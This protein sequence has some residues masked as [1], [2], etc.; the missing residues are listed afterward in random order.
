MR[1]IGN[2]QTEDPTR[3]SEQL[4]RFQSNVAAE[5][6]NIRKSFT[7]ALQ[8]VQFLGRTT[9]QPIL[10]LTTGQ[11]ALCDVSVAALIIPLM[12]PSDGAPGFAAL[13]KKNA[14]ATAITL[15]P[16]GQSIPGVART[17][18]GAAN[19]AYTTAAAGLFWL[20]FDGANW[21]AN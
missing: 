2:F 14:V 7:P 15:I 10:S 1:Q 3:L 18:N 4:D 9:N 8:P 11:I 5:T 16:A 19:K 12:A 20:F 21:W 13:V 6:T 17:I